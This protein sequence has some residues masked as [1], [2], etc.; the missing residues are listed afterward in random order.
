MN[1]VKIAAIDIG[2]NSIRLLVSNVIPTPEYTRYKKA[3]M[4]LAGAPR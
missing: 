1:I 4:T 2:S 3:S